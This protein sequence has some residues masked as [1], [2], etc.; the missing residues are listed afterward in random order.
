MGKL[1]VA[2]LKEVEESRG[3][4]EEGGR[5][6]EKEKSG[7]AYKTQEMPEQE[8]FPRPFLT[9]SPIRIRICEGLD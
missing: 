2:G 1:K 9:S 3:G 8:G 5:K 7:Q 6:R 4:S